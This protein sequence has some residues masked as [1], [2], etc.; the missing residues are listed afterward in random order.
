MLDRGA[1]RLKNFILVVMA[2]MIVVLFLAL[3]KSMNAM[4]SEIARQEAMFRKHEC[5]ICGVMHVY[6]SSKVVEAMTRR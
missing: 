3:Q 1:D 6:E 2:I 4:S 5:E